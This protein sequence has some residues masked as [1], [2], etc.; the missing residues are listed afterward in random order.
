MNDVNADDL[1]AVEGG[2]LPISLC[3]WFSPFPVAPSVVADGELCIGLR[4]PL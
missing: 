4:V 3:F 2:N 1:P